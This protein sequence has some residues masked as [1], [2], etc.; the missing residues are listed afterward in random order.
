[1]GGIGA[2]TLAVGGGG[3]G[4]YFHYGNL[5]TAFTINRLGYTLAE[6]NGIMGKLDQLI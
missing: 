3:G 4:R 1:M 2:S 5:D 6:T